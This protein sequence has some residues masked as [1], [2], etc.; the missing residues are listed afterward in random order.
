MLMGLCWP[1]KMEPGPKAVLISLADQANDHGYCW[2]ATNTIA[3]RTCL[4][5]RTVQRA[6]RD[7]EALGLLQ[8]DIGAMK[9]NRYVLTVTAYLERQKQADELAE[10]A[11]TAARPLPEMVPTPGTMPPPAQCH[12]RHHATPTP[13]TMPPPPRHH[14][15][16]TVTEPIL[17]TTPQTPRST[18]GPSSALS[19]FSESGQEQASATAEATG[20]VEGLEPVGLP[21]TGNGRRGK[22]GAVSLATFLAECRAAGQKPILET[23]AVFA[24][25]DRVGLTADLLRLCW[26][27]FKDRQLKTNSKQRDWRMKYRNAVQ[28]NWYGLWYMAAGEE[29]RLSSKGEQAQRN[30]AALDAQAAAAAEAAE[31]HDEQGDAA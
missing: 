13:G 25:A 24:Y 20:Q 1:L 2:P 6:L 23:D 5:Q 11:K 30:F 15:T 18:K 19:E 3:L 8:T 7:L 27:E 12:P 29:A 22:T 9:S 10:L 31:N 14:A 21:E 17:N 4:H 16:L 28:G 26:R